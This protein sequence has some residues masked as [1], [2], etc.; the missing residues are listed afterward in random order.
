MSGQPEQ[1]DK[2]EQYGQLDQPARTDPRG[3]ADPY[4]DRDALDQ[5]DPRDATLDLSRLIE[6]VRAEASA[7][8]NGGHD[9]GGG[10]GSAG[11]T[12][13]AAPAA[14]ARPAPAAHS[15]PADRS[16]AAARPAPANGHAPANGRSATPPLSAG[17]S[18]APTATPSPYPGPAAAVPTVPVPVPVLPKEAIRPAE[19]EAPIEAE[20]PIEPEP[21]PR[22]EPALRPEPAAQ[23]SL[24]GLADPAPARPVPGSLADLR[25]RLGRLP[26]GHP[27]S[28]Y[29][30]DGELKPPPPRLKHLE[31]APPAPERTSPE[32][33]QPAWT[34]IGSAASLDD[35]SG[36]AGMFAELRSTPDDE[37]DA[38]TDAAADAALSDEPLP[39][40]GVDVTATAEFVAQRHPEPAPPA[41]TRPKQPAGPPYLSGPPNGAGAP[42]PT[43]SRR[44]EPRM[45]AD[46]SWTWGTARLSRELLR[47]ADDAYDRF[48]EAEGRNLF[49]SYLDSGLSARLRD[50]AEHLAHARLAS[51]E[52]LRALI[53]PDVFRARF[54]DMLR[55]H[56]E[57]NPEQLARRVPGALTYSF[58]F[59]AES[60]SAGIWSVQDAMEARGFQLQAR[61]N[62]WRNAE[63]R[64]VFTMW[65]DPES[66]LPFEIQFHTGASLEARHLTRTSA[67]LLNDPRIPASE[68]AS[69]QADLA[70]AWAALPAPPG[71][72]QIDDY[73][74]ERRSPAAEQV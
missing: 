55:R 68:A 38:G 63:N 51:D 27:S 20:P 12:L 65:R 33:V 73:R 5:I 43:A 71:N 40:S 53:E 60:Y 69:L 50:I 22:P 32:P 18:A 16:A 7:I 3:H 67:S 56:P 2:L 29:H 24:P 6:R 13:P 23:A 4:R 44:S 47:V 72:T 19:A 46:G 39:A 9:H 54:A 52:E 17:L 66:K 48:G 28:P 49:G 31:L 21:A 14:A 30:G 42:Q 57:R 35:E 70:S 58:V 61:K 1:W 15:A 11:A 74:R 26:L 8:G 64:G 25:V 59:D 37:P 36:G 45:E 62:G 34:G 41:G 10:A